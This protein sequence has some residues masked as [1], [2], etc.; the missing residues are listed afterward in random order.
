MVSRLDDLRRRPNALAGF[1][2]RFGVA[3]R[4][5]FTG[6]SH[7]AWPDRA[8]DGQLRAFEDAAAL[9]DEKWQRAFEQAEK[10]QQGFA[11]LLGGQTQPG[12]LA[13]GA[14]TH[15]LVV[16][17]LSALPL[18]QRPK[19]LT[20]DGEYHTLRRQLARLEEEGVEVVREPAADAT[21]LAERLSRRVDDQTAAVLVSSVLFRSGLQ[22]PG[23]AELA[24][25]AAKV[26]AELLVDVYHQLNAV[27]CD[28]EKEG[29]GDAFVVGGGYKYC[30]LGEG[31]CF[32]RVPPGRNLRPII[33]G[34]FAEFGDIAAPTPEQVAYGRGADAFAG[35]TY[36]PTSHY[37][38]AEVFDFFRDQDL[39]PTFLRQI[40][41]HQVGLL[42]KSFDQLDLDPRKIRRPQVDLERLGAFLALETPHAEA[43][44]L[45]LKK[46]KVLTDFRGD[47]LRFGPAPYHDDLQL[48]AA[49]AH[50]GEVVSEL[51]GAG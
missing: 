11:R 46:R 49:M 26:G 29:L 44:H 37:R 24:R 47:S 38:A 36:D 25:A 28:L 43:I 20:S 14:S 32:L 48:E 3:D 50:L 18:R 8:H 19:L 39:S 34:W 5:L 27:P 33:T 22:V 42:A 15:E 4:L 21:T 12:S 13:L 45:E 35:A 23:L 7:Q 51:P 30:Q 41:Q 16:R 2:T 6:H 40:S 10:V 17:F 1:Y 9:V 31:N